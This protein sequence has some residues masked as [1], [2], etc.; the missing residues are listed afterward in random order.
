MAAVGGLCPGDGA[1][2][3]EGTGPAGSPAPHAAGATGE[4]RVLLGAQMWCIA[5]SRRC[6]AALQ[7]LSSSSYLTCSKCCT[8]RNLDVIFLCLHVNVGR[9]CPD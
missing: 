6:Q 5:R 4:G 9:C 1:G 8:R 3:E 2:W 7:H